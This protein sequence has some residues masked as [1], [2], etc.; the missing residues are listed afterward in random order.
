MWGLSLSVNTEK[1]QV[2][3]TEGLSQ[4]F[5]KNDTDMNDTEVWNLVLTSGIQ[6]GGARSLIINKLFEPMYKII[7]F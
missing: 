1:R 2:W 3:T 4:H 6:D 7:N 5:P